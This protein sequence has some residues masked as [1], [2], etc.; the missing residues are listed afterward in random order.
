M[1]AKISIVARMK[2]SAIREINN[3][4]LRFAPYGLRYLELKFASCG[5]L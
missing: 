2:R 4:V 1:Q 5:I 3:P